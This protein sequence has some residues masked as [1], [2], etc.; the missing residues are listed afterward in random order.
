MPPIRELVPRPRIAS[1]YAGRP[2]TSF[3]G[4]HIADCLVPAGLPVAIGFSMPALS[5][6]LATYEGP[7]VLPFTSRVEWS[8]HPALL[9]S[10]Q[11]IL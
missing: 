3:L 9:Y 1:L 10:L 6:Y 11:T 5:V 2:D 7:L 4:V 8:A